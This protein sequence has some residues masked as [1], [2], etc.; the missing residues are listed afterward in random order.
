MIA[1]GDGSSIEWIGT[2]CPPVADTTNAAMACEFRKPGQLIVANP[3]VVGLGEASS[4]A[5]MVN[6]LCK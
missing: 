3:F 5:V 2:N 6:R 4:V 1:S